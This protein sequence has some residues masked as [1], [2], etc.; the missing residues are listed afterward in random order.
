MSSMKRPQSTGFH[1]YSS[2]L[3]P[4]RLERSDEPL[5][6]SLPCIQTGCRAASSRFRPPCTPGSQATGLRRPGWQM[7]PCLLLPARLRSTRPRLPTLEAFAGSSRVV[8]LARCVLMLGGGAPLG[9]AI[10]S[11]RSVSFPIHNK[12]AVD[13]HCRHLR[14]PH[15][16]SVYEILLS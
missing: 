6:T 3:R 5:S 14:Y 4:R 11:R 2:S 16:P 8:S 1:R 9:N 7:S 10:F 15:A 12:L 13:H